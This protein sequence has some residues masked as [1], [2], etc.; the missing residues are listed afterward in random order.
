MRNTELIG[1]LPN[2]AAPGVNHSL[3]PAR[4]TDTDQWS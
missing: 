2:T 3:G 1:V 4:C